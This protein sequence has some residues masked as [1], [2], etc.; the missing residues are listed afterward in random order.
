MGSTLPLEWWAVL[1]MRGPVLPVA[2]TADH[3]I[4]VD[5]LLPVGMTLIASTRGT[6]LLPIPTTNPHHPEVPRAFRL[7][8]MA[9]VP[10]PL[11]SS[12]FLL[13][14]LLL[15]LLLLPP[16]LPLQLPLQGV[17]SVGRLCPCFKLS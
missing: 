15:L 13:P 2:S 11:L 5:I 6:L 14:L 12:T 9:D 17:E 10:S 7:A 8:R 3:P 16:L 1:D 4:L